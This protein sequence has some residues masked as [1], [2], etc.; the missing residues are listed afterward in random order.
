MARFRYRLQAALVT[1]ADRERR[2]LGSHAAAR[3][4]Y[5]FEVRELG[6]L[7]ERRSA[8]ES[9]LRACGRSAA[10]EF[11]ALDASLTALERV[12]QTHLERV[13]VAQSRLA[14]ARAGLEAARLQRMALERHRE[15]ALATFE[16]LRDLREAGELDESNALRTL[17]P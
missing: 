6:A 13:A 16:R 14:Q 12:R 5:E 3:S 15:R 17:Q 1:F 9:N 2:A 10:Y 8:T 11:G 4:A 7:D